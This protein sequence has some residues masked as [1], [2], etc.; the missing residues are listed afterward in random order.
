[1]KLNAVVQNIL[2]EVVLGSNSFGKAVTEIDKEEW[3]EID[4]VAHWSLYI[5]SLIEK[6][7]GLTRSHPFDLHTF[8]LYDAL[9]EKTPTGVFDAFH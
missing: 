4:Q 3:K 9:I 2:L 7:V 8:T 5:K 6:T 1:M